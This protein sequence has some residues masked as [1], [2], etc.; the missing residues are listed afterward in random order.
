MKYS[1]IRGFKPIFSVALIS[2][3]IFVLACGST[4]TITKVERVEV[5][6]ETVIVEKE[7]VKTVEV[8]GQTIT[9]EVVKTVEVPGETVVVEVE[10]EVVKT[11]AV[12]QIVEKE[13]IREVSVRGPSGE[14]IM[15]QGGVPSVCGWTSG[16]GG[17]LLWQ[18]LMG[19]SDT[20]FHGG[21]DGLGNP[22]FTGKVVETWSHASDFSYTD[23]TIRGGQEFH[24]GWGPLTA[25]DVLYTFNEGDARYASDEAKALAAETKY[26]SIKHSGL[27]EPEMGKLEKLGPLSFRIPWVGGHPTSK[28]FF[29]FSDDDYPVGILSK[30]A[31]DDMGWEWV[32]DNVIGSGPYEVEEFSENMYSMVARADLENTWRVPHIY[33]WRF[34]N[35]PEY[36][37]RAAMYETSQIQ[38]SWFNATD[39]EKYLKTGTSK[40]VP[41]GGRGGKTLTWMGNF[42]ETVHAESGET[43]ERPYKEEYPW[44][45]GPGPDPLKPEDSPCNDVAKKFRKAMFMAVPRSQLKDSIFNG[46]AD[47]LLSPVA[48]LNDGIIIK[49]GDKWGDPYNPEAAKA[50][51]EEWKT[52]YAALGKDPDSVKI[53]AWVGTDEGRTVFTEALMSHWKSIFGID[54]ELDNTP[55]S[56]WQPDNWR[57]RKAYQFVVDAAPTYRGKSMT[58]EVE[59][60]YTSIGAPQSRNEG[61][62]LLKATETIQ[63]KG[64]AW[65]DPAE[66]ERLTVEW[67]DWLYGQSIMT[68]ALESYGDTIY[69]SDHIESWTSRKPGVPW[70]F[71]DAEYVTLVGQ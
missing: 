54:Y 68:G 1:V 57:G 39:V 67:Q 50:L 36:A 3:L 15:S 6:G 46:Y 42:W 48:N 5:P 30:K 11:V 2:T 45:C 14:V 58:W 27:P 34:L 53:H 44:I 9:K 31:Y 63:A 21:K 4:E 43:L 26:G 20:L 52:D 62:E 37:T 25:D 8:P 33:R 22:R 32:R 7:V 55:Q 24:K 40:Y 59:S 12:P 51:F 69:R 17:S 61:M 41:N 23:F 16:C 47:I 28:T 29:G 18:A 71:W 60:W 10:K 38:L 70:Y 56:T 65:N 35:V 66:L 49:Y 64:E 13:V 19:V